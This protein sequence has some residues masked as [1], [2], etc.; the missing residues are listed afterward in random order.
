MTTVTVIVVLVE[1]TDVT[2]IDPIGA[3]R[4]GA[5]VAVDMADLVTD[6]MVG[7]VAEVTGPTTIEEIIDMMIAAIVVAVVTVVT[8]ILGMIEI[9]VTTEAAMTVG[10]ITGIFGMATATGVETI[11]AVRIAGCHKEKRM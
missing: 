7:A 1:V 5:A 10:V 11:N 2:I 8:E 3:R 4:I 6:G 9:A